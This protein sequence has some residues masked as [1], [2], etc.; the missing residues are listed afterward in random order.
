MRRLVEAASVVAALGVGV[1]ACS[2]SGGGGSSSQPSS[3]HQ[4]AVWY[5]G[6]QADYNTVQGDLKIVNNDDNGAF[7]NA[8]DA[9]ALSSDCL[10]LNEDAYKLLQDPPMPDSTLNKRY[11]AAIV[12]VRSAGGSC[13]NDELNGNLSGAEYAAGGMLES[14]QHHW[15]RR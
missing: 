13:V 15:S 14:A 8:G 11:Q 3:Q 9:A 7:L 2:S 5:A 10:T 4:L 6:V 1:A 12:A